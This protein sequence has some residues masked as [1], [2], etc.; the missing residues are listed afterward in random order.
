MNNPRKNKLLP[1]IF[2]VVIVIV[3]A[4]AGY[5]LG[6]NKPKVVIVKGVDNVENDVISNS[7]FGIFW[8]TWELLKSEYLKAN[9][10]RNDDLILG[11]AAGLA[12]AINDPY[13]VFLPPAE[14][15]K[16]NDDISGSF[17]GI[18]AEIGF[19]GDFVVIVAPLKNSP[20]EKYGLR[21]GD[22][23]FAVDA[24]T[25]SNLGLDEIVNLIRGP[26]N[27]QVTLTILSNGD[28][29]P[30]E[31]KITRDTIKIPTLEWEMRADN[32]A[33]LHLFNFNDVSPSVMAK[34][35]NEILSSG[36]RGVVLD[37]R[38]NP[39]GFLHKAVEIAGFFIEKDKTIVVEEFS[40]GKKNNFNSNGNATLKNFPMVL[41]VNKGSA[42]ASEILA[43]ALRDHNN[44]TII[45]ETTFGKGTV[46]ELKNLSGG[47]TLKL[48][49]AHWILP[50]GDLID[51]VGIKP[52][53]EVQLTAKD[54]EADRDPQ[55]DKALEVL[56]SKIK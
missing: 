35:L 9:E 55:L 22:K 30:R 46:Q 12:E 53:I 15:K 5:Q 34:A 19:R 13:T 1:F 14:T 25:T 43:G 54:F 27:S 4:T 40:S 24:T 56:K 37:L 6:T 29:K 44:T 3:A 31:V 23:V 18:G 48:T 11:A 21:A 42:S 28:E 2:I 7:D 32:L 17:T 8:Q 38:N 39:G 52:D 26:R 16:F 33:H 49:V 20:A 41:L 47:S 45:G 10:V 36:G 51:G 50:K